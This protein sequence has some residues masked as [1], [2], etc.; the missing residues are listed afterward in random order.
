MPDTVIPLDRAHYDA[1]IETAAA[2]K[3]IDEKVGTL[4]EKVDGCAADIA[5]LKE[6]LA[7]CPCEPVK[8]LQGD[9][10][11]M[12][13]DVAVSKRTIAIIAGIATFVANAVVQLIATFGGR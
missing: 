1:I 13:T 12:K 4:G 5:E 6:A 7:G 11:T 2:V 9:V 10:E 8:A 3:H